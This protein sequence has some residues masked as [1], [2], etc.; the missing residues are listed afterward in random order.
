M[1]E[2][3]RTIKVSDIDLGERRREDYGDISKLAAGIEKVGLIN[4]LIVTPRHGRYLLVVGGLRLR[5]LQLLKMEFVDVRVF[6][7]VTEEQLRAM[8]WSENEDSDKPATFS[9][10]ASQL[11]P[12]ET[13][14]ER[15]IQTFYEVGTALLE[16]R[17]GRLYRATH[18]TCEEY[19][20][21]RWSM[22]RR[23]ANRLIEASRFIEQLGPIGPKPTSESQVRPLAGLEP[24][25]QRMVMG[26]GC[27][28]VR[29]RTADSS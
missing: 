10:E 26:T 3:Y 16:I 18:G 11:A 19:C 17:D 25:D 21:E 23:Y 15:G 13:V 9:D 7:P 27:R 8:E 2:T 6:D 20:R 29:R 4:K 14:I 24:E 28:R 22:N 1:T 5:A 12:C